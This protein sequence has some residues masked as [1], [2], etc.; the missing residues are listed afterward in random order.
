M[1]ALVIGNELLVCLELLCVQTWL[2]TDPEDW[3]VLRRFR[4]L[5]PFL[6]ARR[7]MLS[8]RPV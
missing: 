1:F 2:L 4:P 7:R 8:H 3:S 6:E 5:V